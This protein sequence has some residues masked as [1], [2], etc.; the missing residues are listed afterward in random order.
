MGARFRGSC[1]E[2]F[3]IP[4]ILPLSLQYILSIAMFV[5]KYKGLFMENSEL[6]NMKTRNNSSLYQ[7]SPHL[8]THQK[9]S[10]IMTSGYIITF[11]CKKNLYHLILSN[12]R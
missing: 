2:L 12:F 4:K 9:D 7:P 1:R 6:Y 3:K 11:Q 5:V 10:T 8:T